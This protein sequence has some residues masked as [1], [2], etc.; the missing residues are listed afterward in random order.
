MNTKKTNG[1]AIERADYGIDE[2]VGSLF[3]P[4]TLVAE[5]YLGNFRRKTPLEPEKTLV[6]AVLEDG[7]RCFQDNASARDGKKKKLFEEA[8][9]WLFCDDSDWLF[10]FTSVCG[11]LGFDPDYIRGGLKKWEKR[12]RTSP[13]KEQPPSVAE[14]RRL[15]S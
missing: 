8:Q 3:Q 7:I 13:N 5:E 11:L 4:D 6:L 10:S 14:A 12:S 1:Y 2:K 15:A 9:Q